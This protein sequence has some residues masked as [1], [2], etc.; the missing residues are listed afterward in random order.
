MS[1][2]VRYAF[3]V[4]RIGPGAAITLREGRRVQRA[5][6]NV[7][8]VA[9]LLALAHRFAGELRTRAVATMADLAARRGITRPRMTQIMNLLL[10]A[11]DIQEELLFLP[12][13]VRGCD[14]VTLRA[15]GYVCGTPIWTEQRERWREINEP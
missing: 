9:R 13:T 5:A 1:A 6:G 8:R 7:P 3:K 12:P 2:S 14:P 11:P 10:L 4:E 15:M